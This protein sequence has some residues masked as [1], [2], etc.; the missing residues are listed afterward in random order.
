MIRLYQQHVTIS[1]IHQ[2]IQVSFVLDLHTPLEKNNILLRELFCQKDYH[3]CWH[4]EHKVVLLE[5]KEYIR[6]FRDGS[7]LH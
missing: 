5:S 2:N 6:L 3:N 1:Q 4:K 7:E